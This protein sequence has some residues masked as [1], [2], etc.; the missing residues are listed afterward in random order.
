MSLRMSGTPPDATVI[1]DDEAVGT[2]EL[3]AAHG[4]ALPVGVHHITVKAA[5]I[6]P[7]IAKST[8]RKGTRPVLLEVALIPVPD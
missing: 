6:S 5:G 1:I 7:G 3:V 4:V 2:L 8:R